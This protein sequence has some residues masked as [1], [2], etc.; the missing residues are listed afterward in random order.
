MS[1]WNKCG[2]Q[3]SHLRQIFADTDEHRSNIIG[4]QVGRGHDSDLTGSPTTDFVMLVHSHR[5][6]FAVTMMNLDREVRTARSES[7]I[8]R[9][10]SRSKRGAMPLW[11][12]INNYK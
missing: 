9:A 8:K 12:R 4:A 3:V 7:E 10:V 6:Q 11:H 2:I 1:L 5:L